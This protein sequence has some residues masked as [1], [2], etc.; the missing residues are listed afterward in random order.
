MKVALYG[1]TGNLGAILCRKLTDAGHMVR[2]LTLTDVKPTYRGIVFIKGDAS[3]YTD[4]LTV[5]QG[6]EA[7]IDALGGDEHSAVRSVFASNIIKAMH[8]SH[9]AR[10]IA[11][12]GSGILKVGPWRFSQLPVFPRG[13][14]DVT[15]DHERVHQMLLKSNLRWTQICPSYMTVGPAKGAYKIRVGHPFLLWRQSVRLEDVADFMVQ[16][17]QKNAYIQEQVAIIN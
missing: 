17:L 3:N 15:R 9:I 13:K 7:V 12:G 5:M 14:E 1:S 2:A 6:C 11:M 8:E 10:I 4:V 16:E